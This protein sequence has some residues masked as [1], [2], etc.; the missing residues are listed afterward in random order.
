MTKFH[1]NSVLYF[2]I[3]Y[4][5]LLISVQSNNRENALTVNQHMLN[6]VDT[7]SLYQ[8][9]ARFCLIQTF[10]SLRCTSVIAAL[11]DQGKAEVR[12]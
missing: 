11:S 6:K 2:F 12:D 5:C 3:N 1:C 10:H 7:S 8:T 4:I 9:L